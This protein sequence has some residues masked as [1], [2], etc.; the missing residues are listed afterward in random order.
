LA[1]PVVVDS[2]VLI[3][4]FMGAAPSAQAVRRLLETDRLALTTLTVFELHCGV[5][6]EDARKD[7]DLL[8]DAARIVLRLSMEAAQ[9][10][11]QQYRALKSSGEAL[12][13]PDLLIAG[14]CLAANLPLLTRNRQHFS[15][16]SGLELVESHQ[17]VDRD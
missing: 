17:I 2:D 15:R 6:S 12:P 3:D 1:K 5:Q 7:V 8:A 16:V 11:A 4:F 10:A 9:L 13:T 14:C